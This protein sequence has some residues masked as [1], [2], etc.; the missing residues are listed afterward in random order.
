M[1]NTPRAWGRQQA[2]PNTPLLLGNTP[3]CVGKTRWHPLRI[4]DERETPPRAWGRRDRE[5]AAFTP[6]E[7]HPHV[8]GEDVQL[9]K[10]KD[11]DRETPPRAWGRRTDVKCRVGCCRNTPPCVG[12]TPASKASATVRRKH[13]HV[14]GEDPPG[15]TWQSYAEETPPRAW[16]RQAA[17][18]GTPFSHRNTPTCVGKTRRKGGFERLLGKHPHVRGE[19]E[20]RREDGEVRTETPPRA[21]GRQPPHHSGRLEVRNTP[22]CVGKTNLLALR[23]TR[24]R[25]HPHVRGEDFSWQQ[26]RVS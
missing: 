10:D 16:G 18:G 1:R 21:W 6:I 7:K 8:R 22:T 17:M 19:D 3:T 4:A 2:L 14:C 11:T 13:P 15:F 23:V 5:I 9:V 25:K 24:R 12:K 26:K 20:A